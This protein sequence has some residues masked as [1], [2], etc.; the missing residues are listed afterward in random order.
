MKIN[1]SSISFIG[2]LAFLFLG[3]FS[4]QAQPQEFAN[5]REKRDGLS[6]AQKQQMR[7]A[8]IALAKASIDY[9]NELGEMQAR[10][11]T[12]LSAKQPNMN[13]IYA[14]ADKI[15][16][17]KN[18][19]LKER[20]AM[21]LDVRSFLSERQ[22][23][24]MANRPMRNKG[25]RQAERGNRGQAYRCEMVGRKQQM[26]KGDRR[27]QF[28]NKGKGWKHKAG[29][30]MGKEYALLGLSEEQNLQ[31]DELWMAHFSET[32]EIRNELEEIRLKQK[33]LMTADNPNKSSI[34][35]NVDRLTVVQKLLAK[36]K[37]DHK[38]QVR[39][40]LT[41]DQLVIFRSHPNGKRNFDKYHSRMN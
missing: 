32:K 13:Q 6:D 16:D 18:Q 24:M 33:H 28:A 21:K 7:E 10:Q 14:N 4:L 9:K 20:L 29:N 3:V 40:I 2:L 39:E 34:M 41:D 15:A 26:C 22:Q 5:N 25:T 37:I 30:R 1:K 12:L 17:L 38:M 23:M 27:G 36:K 11:R 31:M 19:L 35:A 8:R